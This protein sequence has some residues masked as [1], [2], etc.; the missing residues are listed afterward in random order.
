MR[1]SQSLQ[2]D[3][4]GVMMS[5]A[6]VESLAQLENEDSELV[7]QVADVYQQR[8]Q[9]R[10]QRL[11][12]VASEYPEFYLRFETRLFARVSMLA[13][14]HYNE[15]AAHHGEI[16]SK[17]FTHIERRIKET[18]NALPP[19][20]NPVPKPSP[21]DLIGTVPLLNGLAESILEQLASR[22]KHLTFISGDTIIGEGDRGDA[23][24]IISRGWVKVFKEQEEIAELRD[25]DFFG[26]MALLG[27]QVRTA[28]V[29]AVIPTDL[30][31][32]S[33]KD[34]NND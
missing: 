28:S 11:Q 20:T 2:R 31:R 23:L 8:L 18:L 26:E 29:I 5:V 34:K 9:R 16:G 1:F 10:R 14:Q 25:G 22:A 12:Q 19:I 30:L 33:R 32:L 17:T 7:D 6:A 13:A 15:S 27:D 4:V 21:E 24:Y 3:M